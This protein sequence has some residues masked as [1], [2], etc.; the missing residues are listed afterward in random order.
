MKQ[1]F[2]LVI[3]FFTSFICLEVYPQINVR[4]LTLDE[5]IDTLSLSSL[6]AK[7]ETLNFQNEL[8][9]YE[10]HRKSFLPSLSFNLNP[11]NLNRSLKLLQQPSDGSYSYVEDYSNQSSFNVSVNQKVGLT[12]GVLKIRSNL[13]YL[14]E[15][16][17]KRKRF[18]TAPFNIEYSQQLWGEGK[19]Q[20]LE[21][22]IENEKYQISIRKYCFNISQIQNEV[23][24]LFMTTL[25]HKL[26]YELALE[27][28]KNNDTLLYIAKIKLDNGNITEYDFKQIDLQAL[29]TRY[30]YEHSRKSYD[31]SLQRLLNFL[32]IENDSVIIKS[33]HFNLPLAID[34]HSVIYYV[35]KNNPF[36]SNQELQ[37]LEAQRNLLSTK[38]NNSFNGTV[39]LGYGMNQHG[40]TFEEA[41]RH[42]NTKQSVVIRFE[43]PIFQWGIN[44]NK[45]RIAENN[46]QANTLTIE[47][48]LREFD[49]N[50]KEKVS[51]YNRSINLWFLSEKAY[52]LAQ[53][54]YRLLV[55]KFSL[56]K[57]AVNE[58][59]TA[60]YK[61][62]TT[63]QQYYS[64]IK[65]VYSDYFTLRHMS[66]YDFKNEK[67]LEE[68]FKKNISLK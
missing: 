40:E 66:L 64:T 41:Y 15:F 37:K 14:K 3:L 48:A 32:E 31:E 53:E 1:I 4:E 18:S 62:N 57:V 17:S 12:G 30:S 28:Q 26:E 29:N 56:G 43:S 22:K 39:Q 5:V 7:I 34:V 38:L 23:L 9:Q 8:L 60:Q 59:T 46:Y 35:K 20:R 51:N 25:L 36:S 33:P 42:G 65:N 58:L 16:S 63:M 55:E 49:N 13:N 67:E 50:V 47:K 61:Q 6:S 45:N 19:K 68:I 24:N 27:N 11:I 52:R 10:N 44:R 21:N 54:Q 2:K